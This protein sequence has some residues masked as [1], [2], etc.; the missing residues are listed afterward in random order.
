MQSVS[1]LAE[2]NQWQEAVE[3][4]MPEELLKKFNEIDTEELNKE[5]VLD[6]VQLALDAA[7]MVP[8]LGAVPDLINASI[9]V[10]RGDWVGAGLSLVAA[11]PLV[12]DAVGGAKLAYKGAKYA[13]AIRKISK[14]AKETDKYKRRAQLTQ[15]SK[16]FAYTDVSPTKLEQLGVTKSDSDFFM[17][18]VR[19]YRRNEISKVYEDSDV[20][21]FERESHLNCADVSSAIIEKGT[22]KK[23]D[24]YYM[25]R[26][27]DGN[28]KIID[29]PGN[30]A[31]REIDSSKTTPNSIGIA[32]V[33][34]TKGVSW[35][36]EMHIVEITKET[37]YIVTKARKTTDTWSDRFHPIKVQG[38]G[39]QVFFAKRTNIK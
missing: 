35:K 12:G 17:K 27:V 11:V 6:G 21:I 23:G 13:G 2:E 22:A 9:A 39:V 24:K 38:G 30:Y 28:G 14:A 36:R 25:F 10:L 15:V 32:D 8:V 1:R 20:N 4:E 19:Y 3:Q 5:S 31:I 26:R 34:K 37:P 7:G 18:K 29:K 16:E 33:G